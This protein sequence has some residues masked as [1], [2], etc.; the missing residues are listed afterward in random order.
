MAPM[1]RVLCLD[2]RAGGFAIAIA[3]AVGVLALAACGRGPAPAGTPQLPG[4]D[5]K[6]FRHGLDQAPSSLD[7]VQASNLYANQVVVNAYD[8]L[9][10]YKY[11][12]RPYQLKPNLADG[13]PEISPDLLTYRIRIKQ[14]VHFQDDPAFP[15]GQ[16]REVVARDF[17]YSLERQFDPAFRPQGAWFWQG[18]IVGI[19]D[20]KKAGSDY[21]REIPGLRAVDRYTIEVRL[22]RPYP[23]LLDTFA[24]GYAAV[25]PREA[26]ERY[27][28]EFGTHPVGSG[29]FHVVSY[30]SA[31]LVFERN[32]GFR[33]E[34]VDLAAEGYDPA[35]QRYTGV[36]RIQGRAPPFV[37]RLVL[38]FANDDASRWNSFIKGDEIQ[39]SG[40]PAEKAAEVLESREP[41]RLKPEYARRYQVAAGTEAG[42]V[43][44][45][46]NMDFPEFGYNPD[47]DR[48]RR[49]R[50]ADGGLG[51]PAS[52]LDRS[53]D[54]GG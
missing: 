53:D 2:A 30:D 3:A 44:D 21:A 50:R 19:D 1:S 25:V 35:T 29:P 49:R 10:A 38:D 39:D 34:P 12:A 5:V 33:R 37:D 36:E 13:W 43:F 17:V 32:P 18:R 15:D 20:W 52:Q 16:G 8:T 27:G 22:T 24:Q 14:G 4:D 48:E 46:F 54:A 23:Q 6:T 7:P 11:L 45:V 31:R 51:A 40:L 41:L 42:F 26:V 47:P 9:F 28:R